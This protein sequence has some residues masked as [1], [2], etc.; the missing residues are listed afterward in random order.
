MKLALIPSLFAMKFINANVHWRVKHLNFV[1]RLLHA[2]L[3]F[4]TNH[5]SNNFLFKV[6]ISPPLEDR[7]QKIIPCLL[8]EC[9]AK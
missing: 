2:V 8:V 4:C 5:N 9:N 6:N 7:A 3:D 1:Y